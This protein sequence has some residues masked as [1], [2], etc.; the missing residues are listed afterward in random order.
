MDC[1]QMPRLIFV[2]KLH[3]EGPEPWE[4]IDELRSK[5]HN[6]RMA[7]IQVSIGLGKRFKG[8]VDIVQFKAYFFCG[9]NGNS[10]VTKV[11]NHLVGLV[12]KKRWELI[13]TL[14]S[15]DDYK[16]AKPFSIKLAKAFSIGMP[17]SS[18]N[19]EEV[20][21]RATTA[22]K[23]TPIFMSSSEKASLQNLLDAI[24]TYLPSPTD[25]LDV[26]GEKIVLPGNPSSPLVAL[27]FKLGNHPFQ[28]VFT[29]I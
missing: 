13:R 6:R 28:L 5:M 27:C 24:V 29:Y 18:T 17:I 19:L 3:L 14:I 22:L 20:V 15:V 8:L 12:L 1:Y 16:L 26:M 21:R 10:T 4:L 7:A 9:S 11:P 23:F 25:A 2:D